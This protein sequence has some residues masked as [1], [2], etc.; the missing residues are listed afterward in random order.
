MDRLG[1][2]GAMAH[3]QGIAETGGQSLQ[4]S[5]ERFHLCRGKRRGHLQEQRSQLLVQLGHA[6]QENRRFLGAVHQ[7]LIVCDDFREFGGKQK[8]GGRSVT[9]AGHCAQGRDRIKSRVQLDRVEVGRV[10]VQVLRRR[11]PCG[12]E[13]PDPGG[14]A[15]AGTDGGTDPSSFVNLWIKRDDQ[16]GLAGGGNKT[17]KLEFLI[18]DALAQGADTIITTGAVQSN[19][20]RQTAAA[21]AKV[22]LA[23]HLVLG[24]PPP[25]EVNGNLLLDNLL[26]ATLHWT[27]R[28]QRLETMAGLAD[29]RSSASPAI[30]SSRCSRVVQCRVAPSRLSSSRL[31]F[32]SCGGGPP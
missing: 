21:A 11:S 9:P 4:V 10:H 5:G 3:L 2:P 16:T 22:G 28:E 23:C 6:L 20:C 12:V 32:T 1:Q 29:R 18:A 26:G 25:Q 30:V 14:A 7:P 24:G 13:R 17:R 15:G 19:H 31:P 27:T 8:A